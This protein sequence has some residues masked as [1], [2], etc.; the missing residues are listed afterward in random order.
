MVAG[1]SF[2]CTSVLCNEGNVIQ[3][4][5]F[6]FAKIPLVFPVLY[7]ASRYESRMLTRVLGFETSLCLSCSYARWAAH[8]V[9]TDP[10]RLVM[11]SSREG[12]M[13]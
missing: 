12:N 6:F 5:L 11:L 8:V 7:L 1:I 9:L 2:A 13:L 10:V 4:L 3:K